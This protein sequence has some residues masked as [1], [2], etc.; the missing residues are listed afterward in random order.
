MMFYTWGH[1]DNGPIYENVADKAM[2]FVEW[3]ALS[4]MACMLLV[5][6]LIISVAI[7]WKERV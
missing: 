2:S 3:F 6:L 4:L 5:A 1:I 7:W